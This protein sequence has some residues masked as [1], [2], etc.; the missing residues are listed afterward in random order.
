MKR[1]M[2][3]FIFILLIFFG[4]TNYL[5]AE[6]KGSKWVKQ[7]TIPESSRQTY[8]PKAGLFGVHSTWS[9]LEPLKTV[10]IGDTITGSDGKNKTSSFVVGVFLCDYMEYDFFNK[11]SKS[12]TSSIKKF[13]FA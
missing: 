11:R 13:S 1:K 4:L 9:P 2:K 10:R 6:E 5:N 8:L 7:I 12:I 3:K